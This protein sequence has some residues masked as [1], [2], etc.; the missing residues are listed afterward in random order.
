MFVGFSRSKVYPSSYVQAKIAEQA[1][2]LWNSIHEKGA[3]IY[4]CGSGS[5]V[6]AG[7]R[8]ALLD[9]IQNQGSRSQ[10]EAEEYLSRLEVS[11]R[12]QQDVWG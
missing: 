12:Y 11:G 9:I 8:Q 3:F 4:I 2:P 5:R 7:T 1:E 10:E 6:G